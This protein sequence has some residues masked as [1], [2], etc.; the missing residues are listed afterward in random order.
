MSKV[1]INALSV[2]VGGGQTFLNGIASGFA[3]LEDAELHVVCFADVASEY[4][5]VLIVPALFRNQILRLLFELF[6]LPV[7][8]L[9]RGYRAMLYPGNYG[10]LLPLV[11]TVVVFQNVF[12]FL[13]EKR[14]LRSF[15]LRV[16]GRMSRYTA[17]SLVYLSDSSK[18]T[19]GIVKVGNTHR[20][21]IGV[22]NFFVQTSK[23][24]PKTPDTILLVSS[25]YS[26]KNIEVV[27]RALALLRQEGR[28]FTVQVVG[29][30]FDEHYFQELTA[31]A[32][33]LGVREAVDFAGPMNEEE[34]AGQYAA[35]EYF[36]APAFFESFCIP[37]F[38][39]MAFNQ[40]VIASKTITT[41]AEYGFAVPSFDP[42]SPQELCDALQA[43]DGSVVAG[44][45]E[46]VVEMMNWKTVAEH[47]KR[48][49]V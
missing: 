38:E 37:L 20:I 49:L 46:R 23:S 34:L 8:A 17:R 5:K 2:R 36:V 14:S 7:L 40:K 24:E 10:P 31:L 47:Y 43:Y 22:S 32:Q 27:L 19:I 11:P 29:S 4:D 25:I 28:P 41:A 1:L 35:V 18:R 45:R 6:L 44:N 48:L 13:S 30:V 26:Y 39:A 16:L 42:G 12:P 3:Q 15:L 21:P 33:A 9:A